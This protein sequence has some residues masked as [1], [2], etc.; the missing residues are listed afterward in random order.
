MNL[1]FV[2]G[3]TA[4]IVLRAAQAIASLVSI[5]QALTRPFQALLGLRQRVLDCVR[6]GGELDMAAIPETRSLAVGKL[7]A[8]IVLRTRANQGTELDK[9]SAD[10]AVYEACLN[11]YANKI[12]RT[13]VRTIIQAVASEFKQTVA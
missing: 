10:K 6:P 3:P 8:A 13:E 2:L 5:A 11:C 9:E 7:H 4:W 12:S 1:L